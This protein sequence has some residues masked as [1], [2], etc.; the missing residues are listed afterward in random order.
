MNYVPRYDDRL[1][2][3]DNNNQDLLTATITVPD[4]PYWRAL[5][6]GA[7]YSLSLE[8]HWQDGDNK[9]DTLGQGGAIAMSFEQFAPEV[10]DHPEKA[11]LGHSHSSPASPSGSYSTDA[12]FSGRVYHEEFL[13][14]PNPLKLIA[15]STNGGVADFNFLDIDINASGVYMVNWQ[16]TARVGSTLTGPKRVDFSLLKD[17]VINRNMRLDV[18]NPVVSDRIPFAL[19]TLTA[20]YSGQ[21]LSFSGS[22]NMEV[23]YEGYFQA[24]L[25]RTL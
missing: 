5:V 22:A 11:D 20:F 1:P 4:D 10:H 16:G 7:L 24:L 13:S 17:F 2:L 12:Y 3:P 8:E 19:G 18:N 14:G 6:R 15:Y 9:A 21:K 23:S 25:V